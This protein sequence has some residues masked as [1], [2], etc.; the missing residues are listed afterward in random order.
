MKSRISLAL[1]LMV[2]FLLSAC[3][4]EDGPAISLRKKEERLV[5]HWKLEKYLKNG[6]DK[7]DAMYMKNYEEIYK[8]N[9]DLLT[10]FNTPDDDNQGEDGEWSWGENKETVR[11]SDLSSLPLTSEDQEVTTSELTILRLKENEFWYKYDYKG[12]THEFHMKSK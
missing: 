7:T 10:S 1:P 12:N 4:Y 8:E 2:L 9:G 6:K 5:N 11:V 3:K